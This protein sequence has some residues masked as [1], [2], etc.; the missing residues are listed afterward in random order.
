MTVDRKNLAP[1]IDVRP[2]S[3]SPF[4]LLP[5][6]WSIHSTPFAWTVEGQFFFLAAY[7]SHNLDYHLRTG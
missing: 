5:V 1:E 4:F 7:G 6:G 2:P 3:P